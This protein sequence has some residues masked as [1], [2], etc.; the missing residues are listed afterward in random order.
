M[1]PDLHRLSAGTLAWLERNLDRFDP[2]AAG[3][4]HPEH[5]TS[6][7]QAKAALELALLRHCWARV[8]TGDDPRLARVTARVRTLWQHPDFPRLVTADPRCAAYY[9]L[10]YAALAPDGIDDRPCRAVLARLAADDLSPRGRTPYQRLELR[11]YADKAGVRHTVEPYEELVARNVLVTLPAEA[12]KRAVPDGEAPVTVPEAYAVTH[13][14]FYLS[15]FGRTGAGLSADALA[16]A[17]ELVRRLLEHCVRRDWWDLAAELLLTQ[18]CLGLEPLRTPWGTAAV[19]CLARA[20]QS[21]G[22][23]PGRSAGT[24]V[25]A[26]GP[27]G[28][29]FAKAYHTTLVT[30]MMT[31]L[32]APAGA[33]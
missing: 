27:A 28:A 33:A 10:V 13:S 31:L 15:D 32:V 3:P 2:Y 9:G 12:A 22:A 25:T 20:Q 29:F 21:D 11:Y 4:G 18:V 23:I 6:Y 8:D 30:A 1:P 16:D 19:A 17:A 24:R 14:S 7:A 26:D 5:E